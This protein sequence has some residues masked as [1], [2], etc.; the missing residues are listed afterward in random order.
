MA[1]CAG[2]RSHTYDSL[3]RVTTVTRASDVFSYLHD[4]A[5]NVTS[6]YLRSVSSRFPPLSLHRGV[7]AQALTMHPDDPTSV[8][9]ES[10]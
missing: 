9:L 5:G 3:D 7:R 8:Q 2:S 10:S 4:D 6:R 1:D